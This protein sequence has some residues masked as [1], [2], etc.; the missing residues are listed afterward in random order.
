ML[1]IDSL[2][3]RIFL[4]VTIDALR[5]AHGIY[6]T[7]CQLIRLGPFFFSADAVD[8]PRWAH[9]IYNSS[10]QLICLGPLFLRQVLSMPL[11]GPIAHAVAAATSFAWAHY[12][13]G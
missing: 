5:W 13:F 2:G 3:P 1:P 4:A 7:S 6:N 9:S 11:D 10:C 12:F 8:A